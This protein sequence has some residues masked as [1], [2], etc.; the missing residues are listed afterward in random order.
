MANQYNLNI[1]IIKPSSHCYITP[2]PNLS[3]ELHWGHFIN[4][5]ILDIQTKTYRALEVK[6]LFLPGV[7]YG[8]ISS[9]RKIKQQYGNNFSLTEQNYYESYTKQ[10]IYKQFR[11][12]QLNQNFEL[13]FFTKD[14]NFK[15]LAYKTIDLLKQKSLIFSDKYLVNWCKDCHTVLSDEEIAYIKS[16]SKMYYFAFSEKVTMAT[17]RPDTL[18]GDVAL[19]AAIELKDTLPKTIFHPFIKK[20]IPIL[21]SNK[22]KLNKGTGIMK[23]APNLSKEDYEIALELNINFDKD[24]IFDENNICRYTGLNNQYFGMSIGNELINKIIKDFPPYKIADINNQKPRCYKCNEL[25]VTRWSKELFIDIE[26]I[27]NINTQLYINQED[28]Q[29]SE[30]WINIRKPWCISRNLKYGVKIDYCF[31]QD[32][33]ATCSH[34]GCNK[35]FDTW[36]TSSLCSVYVWQKYQIPIKTLISGKDIIHFW[37]NRMLFMEYIWGIKSIQQVYAHGI[38]RDTNN[39]K[40]SK[41]L[42]NYI[43]VETLINEKSLNHIRLYFIFNFPSSDKQFSAEYVIN[44][45]YI[46]KLLK[47][48]T[49]FKNIKFVITTKLYYSFLNCSLKPL[50]ILILESICN[51]NFIEIRRYLNHLIDDV[52]ILETEFNNLPTKELSPD[53]ISSESINLIF[54]FL[55]DILLS[56]NIDLSIYHIFLQNI[57]YDVKEFDLSFL[58]LKNSYI[59][60]RNIS[61]PEFEAKVK[62]IQA[63]IRKNKLDMKVL[64]DNILFF[65]Y[66]EQFAPENHNILNKIFQYPY[67]IKF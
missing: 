38:L 57:I 18:F 21:Y 16:S 15:Q 49:Y 5:L 59:K 46:D 34:E 17:T 47:Q 27:T 23:L 22:I 29:I 1:K 13:P 54:Q 50:I 6:V 4:S 65:A 24:N 51:F 45:Q 2:P 53:A 35:I 32:I 40:F 43:P 42:S 28:K 7:D 44:A 10:I 39:N 41:S 64:Y 67:I 37:I 9:E 26:S 30:H 60:H 25:I 19:V 61:L 8:G 11:D 33:W 36:F 52:K 63:E 20:E 14:D 55:S 56:Q 48:I 12:W 31:E 62:F 66:N 3:G 58:N